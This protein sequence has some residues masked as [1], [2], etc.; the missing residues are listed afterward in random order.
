MNRL[1]IVA[2]DLV[3]VSFLTFVIFFTIEYF[4]TGIITNYL[5]FNALLLIL[6]A[7]VIVSG[8]LAKSPVKKRLWRSLILVVTAVIVMITALINILPV[9]PIYTFLSYLF[10]FSFIIVFLLLNQND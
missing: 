1:K 8:A 3:R 2:Q 4:K 9:G 5:N 7:S 6:I 10:G